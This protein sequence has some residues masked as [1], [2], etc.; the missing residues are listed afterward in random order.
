MCVLM[1]AFRYRVSEHGRTVATCAYNQY[2]MQG[3]S[4]YIVTTKELINNNNKNI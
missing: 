1:D 4:K 2:P 3:E